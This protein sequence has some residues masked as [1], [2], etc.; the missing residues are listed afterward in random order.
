[1]VTFS[2]DGSL[3]ASGGG[4]RTVRIWDFHTGQ[5]LYS[6]AGHTSTV[7]SLAFSPDGTRLVSGGYDHAVKVWDVRAGK[8]VLS[9][10]GFDLR[11]A[12]VVFSPDGER[13][14]ARDE[15]GTFLTWSAATGTALVPDKTPLPDSAKV[16]LS[17]DRS[18]RVT[19]DGSVL[20]VLVLDAEQKQRLRQ[21][22][23]L[24]RKTE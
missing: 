6:L 1:M 17:P 15:E 7:S 5:Q 3:L 18:V 20:Q 21:Q 23:V 14:R 8:E 13:V 2:A 24:S 11:V 22:E 4:D 12:A 16:V 10:S 19:A 9:L